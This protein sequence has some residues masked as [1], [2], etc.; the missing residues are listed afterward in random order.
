MIARSRLGILGGTLDPVHN[1]HLVAAE[2]ARTALA[3]DRVVLM[4]SHVPPHRTSPPTASRYHRFAMAA[5]AIQGHDSLEVS[6]MELLQPGPT[7]TSDTLERL[8]RLGVAPL[9]IFFI[10]GVDA[11]AEIETWHRYPQVLEMANFIVIARPGHGID[12]LAARLPALRQ[13]MMAAPAAN[14]RVSQPSVF[15][16]DAPTPDVSS[17]V[18]RARLA[19]GQST[20]GML[21]AAVEHYITHHRL[22]GISAGE[23]RLLTTADHLH[24]QD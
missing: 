18:I 22:Y 11:F 24:G 12:G 13:R 2:A 23:P 8:H 10:T 3:L 21:P 6:D 19:A 14:D 20:E 16:V 9:Q 1:G 7:Y 4:P 15:L 5:L 17:T